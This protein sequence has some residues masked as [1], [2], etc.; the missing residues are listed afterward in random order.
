MKLD[1]LHLSENASFSI[2]NKLSVIGIFDK[3]FAPG[4]PA[5]NPTFAISLGISGEKGVH[6]LVL[7][8]IHAETKKEIA[9]VSKND[10]EIKEGGGNARIVVTLVNIGFPD[11]GKYLIQVDVDGKVID[12]ENYLILEK[13]DV[14]KH[15]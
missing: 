12:S 4:F 10:I 6:S 13:R 15:Q 14:S 5:L 1:F 2:D 9:K 8:I 7:K 3:M 11:Q